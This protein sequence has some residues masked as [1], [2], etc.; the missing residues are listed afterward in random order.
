MVGIRNVNEFFPLHAVCSG[1]SQPDVHTMSFWHRVAQTLW[2]QNGWDEGF[3]TRQVQ[4]HNCSLLPYSNPS[5][6]NPLPSLTTPLKAEN[7]TSWLQKK[8]R[9]RDGDYM[10]LTSSAGS[11][12]WSISVLP[13]LAPDTKEGDWGE[14]MKKRR[15]LPGELGFQSHNPCQAFPSSSRFEKRAGQ[16]DL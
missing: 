7:R 16:R 9:G 14:K 8:E 11:F 4:L 12:V 3:S 6:L 5:L 15:K 1:L 10:A 13:S 2:T